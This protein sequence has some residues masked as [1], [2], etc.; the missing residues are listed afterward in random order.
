MGDTELR[1]GRRAYAQRAWRDAYAALSRADA[2]DPLA[3]DDL[4]LLATAAYML[5]RDDEYIATVERAHH[6]YLDRGETGRAVR[7]AFW[8]GM[9]LALRGD[10]GPAS[11]WLGRAQRLLE[12]EEG[13]SVEHGYLLLPLMFRHEAAGEFA[14]AADVAARAAELGD[15]FDDPDLLALAVFE[16]GYMLI[17]DGR[18]AEGLALMDESMVAATTASLSPIV[19][20]NVYCG[21]ILACQEVFEV[22]RAREWTAAL[23]RW[24]EEQPDM[25]AFTG[26]CLVHRAEIMQLSGSWPDAL[27]E[28]RRAARRFLETRNKSAGLARYREAELLR[29]QGDFA[30]AEDAYGEASR[31][32]WEPQPGLAQ[33]RLAQGRAD[34]AAPAIRRA[35]GEIV[36][37]L[38]RAGLLPAYVEIMLAV[39]ELDEARQACDELE[40]LAARYESAMLG[41]MLAHARGAVQLAGGDAKDALV[42]LRG[43][44]QAWQALEA[45]YEEART[46]VLLSNACRTLGDEDAASLE[47]QTA[48]RIFDELGA[49]PDLARLE[50]PSA[51]PHGLSGREL[52]VLRLVA[53]GKTNRQI[54]AAL[55]I[56]EHTVARHVQNIFAKLRLSSRTAATA[57][58][59]EHDL[60]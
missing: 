57:F 11:G 48:R 34:S 56:S 44:W 60:V 41:A 23:Q 21:V 46:R 12:H 40:Q 53:A 28:A 47:L 52:E 26:R 25:V 30:A 45:P 39:G 38:K 13:E 42:T 55:V 59:F 17:K 22:G 37:P 32:G 15:A 24:W 9:T 33:L 14:T 10:V 6:R 8:I 27:E 3:C 36:E 51:S 35:K 5:G 4:E 18:V 19:T 2:A 31:L 50:G 20:G 49:R 1:Q 58:A 29:L 54:A 16:R 7:C 43:A